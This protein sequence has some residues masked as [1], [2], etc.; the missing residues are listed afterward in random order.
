MHQ[1]KKSDHY[2]FGMKAR[3][4]VDDDSGRVHS[5]IGTAA[6]VADVTQV[7]KMLHSKESYFC[8]DAGYTGVEKRSLLRMACTRKG[9][10]IEPSACRTGRTA[11]G[12]GK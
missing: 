6:N 10:G 8:E 5:V 3:I 9:Q 11:L 7:D 12:L 1:T 4:G 2:Y